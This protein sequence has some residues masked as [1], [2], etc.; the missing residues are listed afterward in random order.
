[1]LIGVKSTALKLGKKT[2]PYLAGFSAVML[3]CLTATG[4]MCDHTWPYFAGVGLT[5]A[6]LVYQVCQGKYR[7]N[8]FFKFC[9]H[10]MQQLCFI[11]H[12]LM[13][14]FL[15]HCPTQNPLTFTGPVG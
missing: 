13:L 8:I 11:K 10:D 15:I 7:V 4:I 12:F 1:M 6:H 3:S 5:G 2:K 14:S 9:K